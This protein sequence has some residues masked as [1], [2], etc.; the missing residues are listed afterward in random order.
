MP[1]GSQS[2]Q[3][4]I[5]TQYGSMVASTYKANID[6]NSSIVS[7]PAGSLY[8][9]PNNPAGLSVLVDDGF[10][11]PQLNQ[12]APWLFNG[13][14]SPNVVSLTAPG[15]NSYYACIYW[16]LTTSTTGVIY[17][18][19]SAS[20]VPVVPDQ[21]YLV[22]LAF[23]LIANG[24]STITASNI[25]DARFWT[26]DAPLC[27]TPGAL[28][29]STAVNCQ[30]ASSVMISCTITAALTLTLNNLKN[31]VPV[32]IAVGN[33][34][35]SGFVFK[36]AGTTP[37]GVAYAIAGKVAGASGVGFANY[38]TSGITIAANTSYIFVGNS[39][40]DSTL[41]LAAC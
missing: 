7:N 38:V 14:S 28:S 22:P 13:A 1:I 4:Y 27:L 17:G 9:Y 31:A 6:S 21:P 23:V 2:L 18:T 24:A 36:F 26:P 39:R 37:G 35:G 34:T 40:S 19:A 33:G 15:S 20:P 25:S 41:I 16:N 8:V 11:V 5:A 10:N 30:G 32:W 3:D 12:T 29:T